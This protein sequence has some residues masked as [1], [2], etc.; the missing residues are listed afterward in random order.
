MA[1][2]KINKFKSKKTDIDN[3]FLVIDPTQ[4]AIDRLTP[5]DTK[6]IESFDIVLSTDVKI[7]TFLLSNSQK[8]NV[9][10]ALLAELQLQLTEAQNDVE[11]TLNS[12]IDED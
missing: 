1:N 4:T 10:D 7:S 3:S 5:L 9:I 12:I 11:T 8:Q 6:D 2:I